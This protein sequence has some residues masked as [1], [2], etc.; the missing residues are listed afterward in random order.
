MTPEY[1][2]A[3][4]QAFLTALGR[5]VLL[6]ARDVETVLRWEKAGH[7]VHIVVEAIEQA[8]VD[9]PRR[10]RGLAYVTPAVE[11]AVATWRRRRL[12]ENAFDDHGLGDD[13]GHVPTAGAAVTAAFDALLGRIE[14]AGQAQTDPVLRGVLR[15]A[16]VGVRDARDRCARTPGLDPVATLR[17]VE[18]EVEEAATVVLPLPVR[19]EVEAQVDVTLAAERRRAEPAAFA[20][21]RAAQLWRAVRAR[22]GLPAL[23]LRLDAH[24][25]EDAPSL[26]PT[27]RG[28]VGGRGGVGPGGGGTG[29]GGARG[30]PKRRDR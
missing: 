9:A 14:V 13:D 27:P 6:S 18:R 5:G 8:L 17:A 22:V 28:T 1:F 26:A 7:P 4:E 3:V 29:G 16:W 15:D 25:L 11:E 30:V 10:V 2:A 12:G 19:L 20:E 23:V 21:V 24:D